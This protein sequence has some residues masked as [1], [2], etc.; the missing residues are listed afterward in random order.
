MGHISHNLVFLP[1]GRNSRFKAAHVTPPSL[2]ERGQTLL[3]DPTLIRKENRVADQVSLD[4]GNFDSSRFSSAFATRNFD[5]KTLVPLDTCRARQRIAFL[6]EVDGREHPEGLG[7]SHVPVANAA[8]RNDSLV[9]L[10][11]F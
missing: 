9:Y 10:S 1:M 7:E 5:V 4:P 11:D 3:L 6:N 8:I 2:R